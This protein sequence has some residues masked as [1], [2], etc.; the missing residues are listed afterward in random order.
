MPSDDMGPGDDC[1]CDV[2]ICNPTDETYEDV[3]VFVIL[4][5]Y[6]EYFF[7]PS[8]TEFDH[9]TENIQPGIMTIHPLPLFT[10]PANVGS[11]GGNV[12]YAAMTN[13]S[14]TDLF[15]ELDTFTFGWHE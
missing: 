14:I 10:W 11:A 15:G 1:Y 4:D 9:Y 13:Q 3:P 12:F 2:H 7:A 5:V 8:Y 6:G